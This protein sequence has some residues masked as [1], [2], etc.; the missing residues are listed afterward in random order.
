M[1]AGRN[2]KSV[3]GLFPEFGNGHVGGIQ[4]SGAIAW[5][6][7]DRS[8]KADLFL[9]S[10][11][12]NKNYAR[13][14]ALWTAL[15]TKS[16]HDIVL[17]WQIDLL[18]LLPF[19]RHNGKRVVLFLHG[20][21]AWKSHDWLTRHASRKVDLFLSNSN[22]TWNRFISHNPTLRDATHQT[23]G[24]GIEGP[25][26]GNYIQKPEPTALMIARL[27]R[28]EDYKGHREVINVWPR[29][30]QQHP[31]AKLLIA[32]GGDLLN[33]LKQIISAMGMSAH[34]ELLG[35]VSEDRKQELLTKSRCLLMPSRNEG[36][37]LVYLEAMRLG[38]PCLV[39]NIDA[40]REVVNP[41]E[42]GL[43]VNPDDS[44]DLCEGICKLMSDGDGWNELSTR[45][46]RRYESA[47][48]AQHF[49]ERLLSALFAA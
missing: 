10:N 38:R 44:N 2:G 47:Y 26:S 11:N 12:G 27:A 6:A 37:G 49:Q 24:L 7:I 9:Y 34:V 21:E 23:V 13:L 3:F 15:N 35:E 16:N 20:I 43:E 25:I 5:S 46:R 22:Y 45:A 30:V 42:A 32:G 33:D 48:T 4:A 28:A 8:T 31:G 40:G 1:P 41:P 19:L 17:V 39:S 29:V 36:F 14:N 18:K